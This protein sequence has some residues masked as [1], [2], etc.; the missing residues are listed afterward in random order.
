MTTSTST[1]YCGGLYITGSDSNVTNSIVWGNKR[2][3]GS[4]SNYSVGSN[5]VVSYSAV[6][7]GC[8]GT[9]NISLSALNTGDGLH[10]K[11]TNPTTGAG[12]EYS[13]GDWTIQEGS[14]VINKGVNEITDITLPETDL[15]GNTRIQ[16]EKVDIRY[17]GLPGTGAYRFS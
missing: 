3:D 1:S 10:P 13:V 14:A 4:V 7:G 8:A 16:K 6:Q 17:T 12:A 11:F 15:A 9:G 5:V 2:G